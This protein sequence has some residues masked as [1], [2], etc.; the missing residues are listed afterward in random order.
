[1]FQKLTLEQITEASRLLQPEALRE[2]VNHYNREEMVGGLYHSNEIT[3]LYSMILAGIP[4][5]ERDKVGDDIKEVVCM[6]VYAACIY[7]FLVG[8]STPVS[9]AEEVGENT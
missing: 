8:L 1:M 6:A 5:E 9:V 7:C 4:K 2:I 3:N